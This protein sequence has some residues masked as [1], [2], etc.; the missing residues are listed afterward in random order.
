MQRAMTGLRY[1]Y[2]AGLHGGLIINTGSAS[3]NQPWPLSHFALCQSVTPKLDPNGLEVV[4]CSLPCPVGGSRHPH[5]HL[6]LSGSQCVPS[7]GCAK[8]GMLPRESGPTP[9]RRT[10]RTGAGEAAPKLC[11]G[12]RAC[13]WLSFAATWTAQYHLHQLCL[14]VFCRCRR[15]LAD[16][17]Q[18]NQPHQTTPECGSLRKLPGTQDCGVS[19][20]LNPL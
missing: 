2:M 10:A 15:P 1:Y 13:G 5:C 20:H 19:A 3:P 14:S 16:I 12:S 7:N 6:H 9:A 4:A 17:Y 11:S 8:F 18:L